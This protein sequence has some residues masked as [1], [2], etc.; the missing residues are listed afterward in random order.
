MVSME[1]RDI[2]IKSFAEWYQGT[3]SMYIAGYYYHTN[4]MFNLKAATGYILE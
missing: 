4:T 2:L 1:I 3:S